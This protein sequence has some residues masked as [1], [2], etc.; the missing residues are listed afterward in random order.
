MNF[1]VTLGCDK[2]TT[3]HVDTKAGVF[4]VLDERFRGRI[5]LG[6][7]V[8]A[9]ENTDCTH[10]RTSQCNVACPRARTGYQSSSGY[11]VSYQQKGRR[12]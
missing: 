2:T 11:R 10:R 4:G 1:I 7:I 12:M 5:P 9:K 6:V 3:G 8:P